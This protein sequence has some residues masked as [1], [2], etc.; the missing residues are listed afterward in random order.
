MSKT[1]FRMF[2]LFLQSNLIH[3]ASYLFIKEQFIFPFNLEALIYIPLINYDYLSHQAKGI[4][5]KCVH[6]Y[7]NGNNRYIE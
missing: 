4:E 7:P 1:L 3:D 2:N 5:Y 6:T